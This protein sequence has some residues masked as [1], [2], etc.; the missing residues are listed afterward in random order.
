MIITSTAE[1]FLK[2]CPKYIKKNSSINEIE[3][4]KT[5]NKGIK[6]LEVKSSQEKNLII[7]ILFF[8]VIIS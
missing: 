8:H 3:R 1:I 2:A 6:S 4:A 7:P 5:I